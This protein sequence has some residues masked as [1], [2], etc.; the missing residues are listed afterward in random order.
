MVVDITLAVM[1]LEKRFEESGNEFKLF[2]YESCGVAIQMMYSKSSSLQCSHSPNAFS[3]CLPMKL[4]PKSDSNSLMTSQHSEFAKK[5]TQNGVG[6]EK[7]PCSLDHACR[8]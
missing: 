5:H 8:C 3:V 7:V 1:G 6:S 2:I 4:E